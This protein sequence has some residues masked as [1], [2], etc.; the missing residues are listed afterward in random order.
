M[1][2][3]SFVADL[4]RGGGPRN[5]FVLSRRLTES[6][7]DCC[8]RMLW[9]SIPQ[10]PVETYGARVVGPGH[11]VS[12]PRVAASL[13]GKSQIRVPWW[14]LNYFGATVQ[15]PGSIIDMA[16]RRHG[17]D[18]YIA[19]AWHTAFPA[20]VTSTRE[21]VPMLYFVQADERTFSSFPPFQRLVEKTYRL[22]VTKFTQSLWLKGHLEKLF[23]H[24]V[25]CIGIGIDREVFR[26][27]QKERE[28]IVFT[29]A[30]SDPNKGF[31][32]FAK[33]MEQLYAVRQDFRIVIAGDQ[34]VAAGMRVKFP[35]TSLGWIHDDNVLADLYTQSIFVNTGLHEALPMPPLEAMASGSSVVASDIPGAAEYARDGENC[36]LTTPG[37]PRDVADKVGRLLDS[38]KLRGQ[39]AAG[40]I[41][42]ASRYTWEATTQRLANLI[43]TVLG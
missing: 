1:T 21:R 27:R 4:A 11:G 35:F 7:F 29:V 8:V 37:D 28:R 42:T 10:R 31:G 36:L 43:H 12:R 19:T 3:V 26:P 15:I 33:A 13:V 41:A 34:G 20:Y 5:V 14:M 24:E 16:R 39:L 23:G 30:R 18:L 2:S 32:V 22:P 9:P 25:T 40:G 6:G 38:D 17:F